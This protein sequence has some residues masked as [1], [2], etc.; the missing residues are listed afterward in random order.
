MKVLVVFLSFVLTLYGCGG[1][2]GGG[3]ATFPGLPAL[4]PAQSR[5]APIVFLRDG[6]QVGADVRPARNA[7]SLAGTHGEVAVSTGR[8]RDGES[9]E[10]VN[11]FLQR[12]A[13]LQ[14]PDEPGS[15]Y[16]DAFN[17]KPTIIIRET[18]ENR[19]V[20]DIVKTVQLINTALPHDRKITISPRRG[21]HPGSGINDHVWSNYISDGEIFVGIEPQDKWPIEER[22][23]V[24]VAGVQTG[25]NSKSS[26]WADPV[27]AQNNASYIRKILAHEIGHA[28]GLPEHIEPG[29]YRSIMNIRY[30]FPYPA[31]ILF[32][33]DTDAL[34]AIFSRF[35]EVLGG[36]KLWDP[37]SLEPWTDTSF[38]LRGDLDDVSFG[39]SSRNGL[40]QPWA[41]G[42]SPETNLAD[43]QA[44]SGSAT[45]AG[46]LLGFT[47]DSQSLAGAAGLTVNLATLTGRID[48]TGLEHW[49]VYTAPGPVGSGT[50]WNDGDLRYSVIVRGNTFYQ[51]GGDAGE[52][53]GML[54]GPNHEGMGGVVERAD[55]SAGFAGKR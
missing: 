25:Y 31:H 3:G 13:V 8:I 36:Y 32:Q 5:N 4:M 15:Q 2:G 10:R 28:L 12:Q 51:T 21:F 39:A 16:L 17:Q 6:V 29:E 26:I 23:P 48:F 50:R 9:A 35:Q 18:T 7:L 49:G 19:Y 44:L 54:F 30:Q 14:Y 46:R 42:P 11:D 41:H 34:Y 40:L 43:N 33:I 38:H 20:D 52:V 37:N 27:T 53:T 45:W 24:K 55:M 22:P 47:S 1:G